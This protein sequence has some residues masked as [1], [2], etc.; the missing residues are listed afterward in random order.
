MLHFEDLAVRSFSS[1]LA[2]ASLIAVFGYC[3]EGML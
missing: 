2:L 1:Y 3:H